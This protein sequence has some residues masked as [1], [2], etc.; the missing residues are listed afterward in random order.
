MIA[1]TRFAEPSASLLAPPI[2]ASSA[3]RLQRRQ[4]HRLRAVFPAHLGTALRYAPVADQRFALDPLPSL[5]R[6]YFRFARAP[7][8]AATAAPGLLAT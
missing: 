7:P 8:I 6:A 4:L 2:A 1:A 3:L 5:G